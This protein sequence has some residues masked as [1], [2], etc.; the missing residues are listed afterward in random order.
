M[1]KIRIWQREIAISGIVGPFAT[2]PIPPKRRWLIEGISVFLNTSAVVGNRRMVMQIV[3]GPQ[4]LLE[5][6]APFNTGADKEFIGHLGP[7]IQDSADFVA[8]TWAQSLT[9]L[10]CLGQDDIRAKDANDVDP[11]GDVFR[12]LVHADTERGD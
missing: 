4:V 3:R 9:K 12:V 8:Q 5:F 2:V 6:R 1:P 10:V 11:V 7:G